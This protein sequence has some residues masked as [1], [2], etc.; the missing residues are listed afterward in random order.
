M[1]NTFETIQFPT[2]KAFQH[3]FQVYRDAYMNMKDWICPAYNFAVALGSI[4][5]ALGRKCYLKELGGVYPNFYQAIIGPSHLAAKSPTINRLRSIIFCL[6]EN[7][8]PSETISVLSS[9]TSPEQIKAEFETHIEGDRDNPMEWYDNNGVRVLLALE[10]MSTMLAKSA[11]HSTSGIP[12]L[13]TEIYH[14]NNTALVNNT[15]DKK[16]RSYAENWTMNI[17]AASTFEWYEKFIS[18]ED[19]MSGFLNRYVFYL[20]EQQELHSR[21]NPPDED[22]KTIWNNMIIGFSKDY[23]SLRRER[24]FILSEKAFVEY[25]KWFHEIYDNILKGEDDIKAS[26]TARVVRQALKLSLIYASISNSNEDNEISLEH[27]QS[28]KAVAT[29][30]GKCMGFTLENMSADTQSR[31]EELILKKIPMVIEKYGE[32]TIRLLK[33]S[34]NSKT[35]SN[36]TFD[37]ALSS[38]ENNSQVFIRILDSG[39]KLVSLDPPY[40]EL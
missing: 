3:G 9:I 6:Q 19:F 4:S 2:D 18:T 30:W 13:L 40:S 24:V 16:S 35:M 7:T 36:L 34:I 15:R 31:S 27:F 12:S 23:Q 17:F 38:L 37:K 29:Y 10:E 28:A 25:D 33:K 21:F 39:K 11:I 5:F 14:P 26:A 20:H 22:S 1:K 8:D 32:C